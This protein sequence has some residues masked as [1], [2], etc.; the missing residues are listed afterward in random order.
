MTL[1]VSKVEVCVTKA[2][3]DENYALVQIAEAR[4]AGEIND[5]ELASQLEDEK[6]VLEATILACQAKQGSWRKKA[7]NAAMDVLKAAID[8]AL[9]A[10]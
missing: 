9:K 6:L 4:L 2:L 5:E 10:V 8:A 7:A 1:V 3:Q